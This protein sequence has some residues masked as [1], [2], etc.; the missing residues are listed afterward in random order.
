MKTKLSSLA[1]VLAASL[2]LGSCT[3]TGQMLAAVGGFAAAQTTTAPPRQAIN[4][5]GAIKLTQAVEDGLDVYAKSGHA[6]DAV[7]A[8]LEILVPALHN[9]LKAAEAAQKNGSSAAVAG[10]L[11]AFNESLAAVDA[12]KTLKGVSQ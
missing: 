8:Q 2:A 11:K 1:L 6:D 5:A 9:T 7:L 10:A 12:Y 3:Q 4:V